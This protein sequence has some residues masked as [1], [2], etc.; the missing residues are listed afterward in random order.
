MKEVGKMIKEQRELLGLTQEELAR[1]CGYKSRTSINKIELGRDIPI[2]K[3]RQVAAALDIPPEAFLK[4]GEITG[5][6]PPSS[7]MSS[8]DRI[9]KEM[10]NLDEKAL[11]RLQVYAE[12]LIARL[13]D[14]N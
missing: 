5:A 2:K 9:E 12:Y 1:K 14:E 3:V 8:V 6:V 4:F 10:Q 13:N 11:K 7:A